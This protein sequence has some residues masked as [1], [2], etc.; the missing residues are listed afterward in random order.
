MINEI[1]YNGQEIIGRDKKGKYC[2][3]I[4]KGG[5][6][7][8]SAIFRD[9][10]TYIEIKCHECNKLF[11]VKLYGGKNGL[12]NRKYICQSCCKIGDKNGFYGQKHSQEFKQRLS[13]ERKGTWG[14]GSKNAMYGINVWDTYDKDKADDIKSRISQAITGE[15]NPFYGKHHSAE[16]KKI[17]AIASKDYAIRHPEHIAKM[18]MASLKKQ[19][20][21]FKSKI[22]KKVEQ[23]LSIR[24]IPKR[25]SRILHKKYQYD[26]IIGKTILLE[27]HG[28]YWHANPLY[29]GKEEGKKPLNER[30]K[31]KVE[32][33]I[34]KKEFAEEYGYKI[35]YIW[36]T[37]INNNNFSIIDEIQ[38]QLKK[39]S[40]NE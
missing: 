11:R 14:V 31:Y 29:Y 25:Y 32:R 24:N 4:L 21:G 5:E 23:E 20:E 12:L 35:F 18:T 28:D 36:E 1:Y 34:V 37:D 9:K 16:T 6:K 10:N 26:F 13:E 30:Q 2:W 38:K 19:S 33:D 7:I 22:E 27:V 39:D 3:F 40:D 15:K 17:L 8:S